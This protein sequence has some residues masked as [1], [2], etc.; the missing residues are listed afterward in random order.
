MDQRLARRLPYKSTSSAWS[1]LLSQKPNETQQV[2]T[3]NRV[4]RDFKNDA[5]FKGSTNFGLMLHSVSLAGTHTLPPAVCE[6]STSSPSSSS[7]LVKS[8]SGSNTSSP[9]H[10]RNGEPPIIMKISL[11]NSK[12]AAPSDL[13][14]AKKLRVSSQFPPK[15]SPEYEIP[16]PPIKIKVPNPLKKKHDNA[17]NEGRDENRFV[18]SENYSDDRVDSPEI[19]QKN[20]PMMSQSKPLSE[21][22]Q[23]NL[24]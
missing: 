16:P 3:G 4:S 1:Q 2:R 22:K 8:Q 5:K 21:N 24:R 20:T 12:S 13:P 17:L 7:Q 15:D 10:P 6:P 19:F 23:V 14:P 18:Q 9:A 11:K